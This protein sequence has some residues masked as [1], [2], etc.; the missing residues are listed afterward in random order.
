MMLRTCTVQANFD[1]A[2][3]ADAMRKMR[4]ALRLSPLT[5]ALF[6]NSPW[7]EGAPHG[8]LT[9]RGRVWLDVDP[10][11]TGLLPRLLEAGA[12]FDSYAQWALDAPMFLFKRG[13]DIVA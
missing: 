8:G 2:S 13:G 3:E 11:R 9:F 5:T 4:V 1:Y 12:T 10:D 6:A 7:L